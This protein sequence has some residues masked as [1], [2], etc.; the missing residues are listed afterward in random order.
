[1]KKIDTILRQYVGKLSVDNLQWLSTRLNQRLGSDLAEALESMAH[2]A[3]LD[4]WFVTAKS[5]QE[6]YDM[7]DYAQ[8]F[9]EDEL[10]SK[11]D[12]HYA[13]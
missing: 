3:D 11:M 4:K 1:M 12:Y 13:R 6:L 7:I 2:F 9:I 8:S 5:S 10:K